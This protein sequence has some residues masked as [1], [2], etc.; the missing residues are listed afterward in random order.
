MEIAKLKVKLDEANR[1]LTIAEDELEVAMRAL[2]TDGEKTV[3]A[4]SLRDAL[5]K[6]REARRDVGEI[7]RLIE[8]ESSQ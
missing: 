1:L 5:D 8:E 7:E 2:S 4:N 6:L 3:V